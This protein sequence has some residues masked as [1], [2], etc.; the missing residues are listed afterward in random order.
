M[1]HKSYNKRDNCFYCERKF[2]FKNYGKGNA[3]LISVDHIIPLCK[4][5]VDSKINT[6][7][8]CALCNSIKSDLTIDLFLKKVK[9]K[10][11]IGDTWGNLPKES[12]NTIMRKAMELKQYVEDK[13]VKLYK[14]RRDN[15][16]I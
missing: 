9:D 4:G 1:S 8:C 3:V 13:G 5:G 10:I 12:L 11:E 15:L 14:Q 6:V 7:V 16:A 2:T